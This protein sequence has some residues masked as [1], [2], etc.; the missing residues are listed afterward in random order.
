MKPIGPLMREHRLI[1]RMVRL[2]ERELGGISGGKEANPLIIDSAVDFLK[3]YADRT[4]HGK[5][6]DIL[7][8]ALSGKRLAPSAPMY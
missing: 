3:T 8:R 7:F 2:M 6:E 1:E 4:H 5:E